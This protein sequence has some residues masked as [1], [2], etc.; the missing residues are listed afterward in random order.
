MLSEDKK[1]YLVIFDLF[2][3]FLIQVRLINPL[4]LL[5]LNEIY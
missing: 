3:L 5:T 1:I 2:S 4:K